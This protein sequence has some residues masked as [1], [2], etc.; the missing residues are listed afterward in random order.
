MIHFRKKKKKHLTDRSLEHLLK[1]YGV[2]HLMDIN[3]VEKLK[4]RIYDLNHHKVVHMERTTRVEP[5]SN[6]GDEAKPNTI[7]MRFKK[8]HKKRQ[9]YIQEVGSSYQYIQEYWKTLC[10]VITNK[11]KKFSFTLRQS[12]F[13]TPSN[14]LC[15]FFRC[16]FRNCDMLTGEQQQQQ[17]QQFISMNEWMNEEK[18]NRH[19]IGMRYCIIND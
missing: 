6:I 11:R 15:F 7:S 14:C 4:S 18:E 17:Q 1:M 16:A 9:R 12:L 5:R 10:V 8:R 19:I 2:F 13:F 3:V